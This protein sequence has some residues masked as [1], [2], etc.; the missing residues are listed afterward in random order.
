VEKNFKERR[1]KPLGSSDIGAFETDA[2]GQNHDIDATYSIDE[3]DSD[4]ECE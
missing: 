3:L 2:I 4:V 1:R